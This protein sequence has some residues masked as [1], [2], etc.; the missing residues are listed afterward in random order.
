MAIITNPSNLNRNTEVTIDTSTML[1]TL[2]VAGNMTSNGVTMQA[3]YSFFYNVWKSDS[4]LIEYPFPIVAITSE[5]YEIRGGWTFY[6]DASRKLIRDAGWSEIYPN[7]DTCCEYMGL[8]SLGNIISNAQPYYQQVVGGEAIDFTYQGKIN[9]DVKITGD[10]THGDF[11]YSDYIRIFVREY[12]YKFDD[13]TNIENEISQLDYKKISLPLSME[14][15]L[16]IENDDTTVSTTSPYTGINITYYDTPVQRS[17][18]GVDYD[19]DIIIEG[20]GGSLQQI[21]EKHNYLMRQ[22][23]DINEGTGTVIGKT[24]DLLLEFIGDSL[25]TSTGVYIDNYPVAESTNLY[26]YDSTGTHRPFPIV[27]VLTLSGLKEG[28]FVGIYDNEI[29]DLGNN[30]T[31]LDYT[32]SSTTSFAYT[33][34]GSTNDIVIIIIKEGYIEQRLEFTLSSSNQGINI[35]QEIDNND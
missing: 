33:H 4:D 25:H 20:N 16:K 5:Q 24:A 27:S 1:I 10:A 19:F 9:E 6:S 34:D 11:D 35:V 22:N 7:G 18:G 15:D 8:A 12:G 28:S 26:V 29:E 32:N 30:N 13:T 31:L 23:V 14:V 21:Y 2:N 3:L 17:I